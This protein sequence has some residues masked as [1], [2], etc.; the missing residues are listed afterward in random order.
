MKQQEE[1][2]DPEWQQGDVPWDGLMLAAQ[3][4]GTDTQQAKNARRTPGASVSNT[5]FF[6]AGAESIVPTIDKYYI[7]GR[8]AG[9]TSAVTDRGAGASSHCRVR[10]RPARASAYY[11]LM[12]RGSGNNRPCDSHTI[13]GAG[14]Q[15]GLDSR[16]ALFQVRVARPNA[17][18]LGASTASFTACSLPFKFCLHTKPTTDRFPLSERVPDS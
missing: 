3:P 2:D 14:L 5:T 4:Q 18:S 17:S 6:Y 12:K 11:R 13:A 8:G 16:P 1:G 15:C 10:F 9:S 7:K